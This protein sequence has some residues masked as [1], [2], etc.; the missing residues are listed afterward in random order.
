MD[1]EELN[2]ELR[3]I[4]LAKK[5]INAFG[6]LYEKYFEQLFL[7]V[8]KRVSNKDVAGDVTSQ[9]FMKALENINKYEYR[10]FPFSSWLYRIAVNEVNMYYRK[11][12]KNIEISIDEN[13][14]RLILGDA[15][16]DNSEESQRMLI[17][18]LNDLPQ[19]MTQL[20]DLRFFER[21][22]FK[23]I[24]DLFGITEDNAKVKLYR[25]LKKMKNMVT[26][27]REKR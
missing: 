25:V 13:E 11:A 6:Y 19:E 18:V 24:G 5:D 15:E 4:Q 1:K 12:T 2:R 16:I 9:V 20:I 26:L 27:K 22:S 8:L 7:F 17:D 14:L 23:E 3:A 21:Q 10:G